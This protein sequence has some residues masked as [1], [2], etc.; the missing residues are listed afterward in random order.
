[1]SPT[2][3]PHKTHSGLRKVTCIGAWHPARVSFTV[4]RAGQNGYHHRT[5][6][7][8]K[9]YKLGKAGHESHSAMTDY[10]RVLCWAKERR[11][12]TEAMTVASNFKGC[13][14]GEIK[15]KFIDASSKFGHDRFQTTQ[16]KAKFNGKLKA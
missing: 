3:L 12:D 14:G 9:V 15:L 4:A 7:N 6:M 2:C 11:C 16:E 5:K 10:D 8:K 13:P 1:M